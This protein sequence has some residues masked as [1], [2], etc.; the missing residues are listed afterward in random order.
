MSREMDYETFIGIAASVLT[1]S[2]LVPQLVKLIK[3]KKSKDVSILMLIV[4]ML[5]LSGWVYYGIL[6]DDLIIIIAN[7]FALLI[8]ILN[9]VYTLRFRNKQ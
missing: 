6:I 4:L 1:S 7:T 3:E 8:N 2:S 9:I 5:G